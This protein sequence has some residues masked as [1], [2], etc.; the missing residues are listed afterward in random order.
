MIKNLFSKAARFLYEKIFLINDTP[1][2]IALGFGLGIF[3][4][5]LPG[6]GPLAALFLAFL[7]KANRATALFGSI[8][9]NTWISLITLL[10]AIKAGALIFGIQWQTLY[11]TWKIILGEFKFK[12]LLEASIVKIILPVAAGYILIAFIF[13]LVTYLITLSIL[14]IARKAKKD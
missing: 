4:G 10:L 3:S 14:F 6:T 8:I 1:H 13:G 12:L 11:E 5:I 7:F 2:K 9:S